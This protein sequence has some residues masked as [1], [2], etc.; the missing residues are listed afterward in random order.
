M[1]LKLEVKGR[2][3]P[4]PNLD[5]TSDHTEFSIHTYL[6]QAGSRKLCAMMPRN[7]LTMELAPAIDDEAGV[8]NA[9]LGLGLGPW[10]T[11]FKADRI[12]R[13]LGLKPG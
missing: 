7:Q 1:T 8:C 4:R 3:A 10:R 11:R 12:Q 6:E 5:I 2:V 9:G 13:S